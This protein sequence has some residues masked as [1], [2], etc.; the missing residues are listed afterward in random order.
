MKESLDASDINNGKEGSS[1]E[2]N[3]YNSKQY[4]K[5]KFSEAESRSL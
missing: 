2:F 3:S 1:E 4:Y 5:E